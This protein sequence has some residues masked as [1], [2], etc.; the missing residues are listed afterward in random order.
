MQL[1][2]VVTKC[3]SMIQNG[4]SSGQIIQRLQQSGEGKLVVPTPDGYQ[5]LSPD[6]IL[7]ISAENNYS[8]IHLRTG[9]SLII[10]KNLGKLEGMLQQDQFIR[11][12]KS[13]LIN[14]NA[15][16]AWTTHPQLSVTLNGEVWLEVAVRKTG[17][18][19]Q[20]LTPVLRSLKI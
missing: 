2:E 19:M 12:H 16:K 3:K 4:L 8:K 13:Y 9:K 20:A 10:A 11:I 14:R 18:F 17:L 1:R 6:D 5:F 15:M 7:W